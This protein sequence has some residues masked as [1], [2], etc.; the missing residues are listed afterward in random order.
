MDAVGADDRVRVNLA[1]VGEREPQVIAR[2]IEADELLVELDD[3][4]RIERHQ[5]GVQLGAVQ[6]NVGRA[7]ALLNRAPMGCR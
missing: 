3:L 6:G 7:E 1:P 2:A 5:R 4:R